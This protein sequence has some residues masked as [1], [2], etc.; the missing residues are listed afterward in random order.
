MIFVASLEERGDKHPGFVVDGETGDRGVLRVDLGLA[1]DI[2]V[3]DFSF[4]RR[5]G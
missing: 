1:I 4:R 5:A 2:L 3:G